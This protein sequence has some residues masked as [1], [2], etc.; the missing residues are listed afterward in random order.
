MV[1]RLPLE[2]IASSTK[3][4][5][6]MVLRL[7]LE[8]I[9]YDSI[10][11]NPYITHARPD[12]GGTH[13]PIPSV[14]V[15]SA[16]TNQLINDIAVDH[17]DIND[18]DFNSANGNIYAT[19][20]RNFAGSNDSLYVI[21]GAS[22]EVIATITI[23]PNPETTTRNLG[24]IGIDHQNN[25]IYVSTTYPDT[26]YVVSGLSHKIIAAIPLSPA[27]PTCLGSHSYAIDN[28][29]N[30]LFISNPCHGTVTAITMTTISISD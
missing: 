5:I 28:D 18:I 26:S 8:K 6:Y 11:N 30:K 10:N 23:P 7:P 4:G 12:S 17:E 22:Q 21:S 14:Y 15:I 29:H 24:T 3:S 16:T 27:T 19:V 1:L 13:P 2:K 20:S 9:A 25:L